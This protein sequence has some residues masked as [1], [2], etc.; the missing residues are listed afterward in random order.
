MMFFI[1]SNKSIKFE[2]IIKATQISGLAND[3]SK[4]QLVT[5]KC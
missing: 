4:F 5:N 3:T 1:T 2:K